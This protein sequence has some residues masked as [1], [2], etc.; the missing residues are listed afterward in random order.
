MLVPKKAIA[1]VYA[2]CSSG[3][4]KYLKIIARF[5]I[6]VSEHRAFGGFLKH[7][8]LRGIALTPEVGGNTG[9][10]KV[11]IGG[12][13]GRRRAARQPALFPT[14]LSQCQPQPAKFYGHCCKQIFGLAQLVEILKEKPV[15]AVIA[16]GA[17]GATLQ[18][19]I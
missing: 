13:S 1:A 4:I 6:P 5:R 9:R 7:P 19:I 18:Q 2:F 14:N 15:F 10:A 8:D 16:G 3:S 11:H 17:L 12:E